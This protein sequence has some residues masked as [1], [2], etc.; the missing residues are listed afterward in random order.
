[1]DVSKQ[2]DTRH[3]KNRW[4]SVVGNVLFRAQDATDSGALLHFYLG[5]GVGV[6]GAYERT[7]KIESTIK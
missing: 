4:I 7:Q 1:M 6:G 3:N 2:P 5:T